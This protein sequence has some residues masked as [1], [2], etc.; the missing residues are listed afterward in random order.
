MIGNF[1]PEGAIRYGHNTK[2]KP[3]RSEVNSIEIK[4]WQRYLSRLIMLHRGSYSYPVPGIN[5][6]DLHHRFGQCIFTQCL[7]SCRITIFA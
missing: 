2:E 5:C 3:R 6:N 1:R 4:K 7:Q